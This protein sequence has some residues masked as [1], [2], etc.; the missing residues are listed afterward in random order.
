MTTELPPEKKLS[1]IEK[2]FTNTKTPEE[3]AEWRKNAFAKAKATKA[4]KRQDVADAREKA[5]ELLPQMLA[6]DLLMLDSD[7]Y[8]PRPEVLD[9]VKAI[10]ASPTM[11]LDR[12]R[13]T[14]FGGMS[15]KGWERLTKF[16]FKE[17]VQNEQHLGLQIIE[18]R[19]QGIKALTRRIR[20]LRKEIKLAKKEAKASGGSMRAPVSLLTLLGEAE[21]ELR[22]YMADVNKNIFKTNLESNKVKASTSINI[23]TTIPR[24][25][26]KVIEVQE[27][28]T[29]DQ[30]INGD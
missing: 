4:K 3:L 25:E 11:T 8:T 10:L 18:Q 24:P 12:L 5:K 28:K 21:K 27:K 14:H 6:E 30:L 1:K 20:M 13:R 9:K 16:L 7:A 22:D 23:H 29:L 19:D 26:P 2:Y 15:N 17:H